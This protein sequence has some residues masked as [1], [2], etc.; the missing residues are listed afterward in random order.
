MKVRALNT[1]ISK[2]IDDIFAEMP[3]V[4]ILRGIQPH[5]V[6]AIADV[7]IAAGI[8]IIEVPLNSPNPFAS[9]ARLAD[10][11]SS[12][13][14]V[15]AGTV[16]TGE[17]MCKVADAKGSIA[18]TPNTNPDVIAEGIKAG[19]VPMPGFQTPSEALAAYAAGAR[20]L[21]MFPAGPLGTAHWQALRA[22]LPEDVKAL[23]VGGV[24]AANIHEWLDAGMSGVG[25]GSEIYKAG[26]SAETVSA[27]AQNLVAKIN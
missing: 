5:E 20:Y 26:D 15:G 11:V 13:I 17:A 3:V 8:R 18:V 27:K 16:L 25:I 23:A 6:T 1:A 22:V 12:D 4:A 2:R 10:H 14:V 24:G 19:L 9:I 21:K 7:L